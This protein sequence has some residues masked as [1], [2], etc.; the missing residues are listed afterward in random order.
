M[1][2][3]LYLPG[4]SALS[5]IQSLRILD[6]YEL[7]PPHMPEAA[8]TVHRQRNLQQLAEAGDGAVMTLSH[9]SDDAGELL[10]VRML[11]RQERDALEERNDGFEE[12]TSFSDDEHNRSIPL[13]VRFD[14]AATQPLTDQLENLSPI[15]ILADVEL[16]DE[17][18]SDAARGVA[19]HRYREASFSVDVTRDVAVQPFL[20]IVRTRHVVTIVNAWSDADDE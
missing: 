6:I 17:L 14:V 10:E 18:E 11:R 7:V 3:G 2:L 16:R 1:Q 9:S 15:A 12:C 13:A 8:A 4:R 19:L 20:L 5:G